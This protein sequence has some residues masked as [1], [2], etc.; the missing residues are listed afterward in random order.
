[1]RWFSLTAFAVGLFILF[2]GRAAGSATSDPLPIVE[3]FVAAQNAND[4]AAVL[5]TLADDIVFTGSG[6]T[7]CGKE[8]I[9][10]II[11]RAATQHRRT[12]T[13]GSPDVAGDT[14]TV[15]H[16]V[17]SDENRALGIDYTEYVD[18]FVVQ[19]GQIVSITSKIT[20][21][22]QAKIEHALGGARAGSPAAPPGVTNRPSTAS[23][24][25]RCSAGSS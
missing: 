13:V 9:R 15:V 7:V 3:T 6:G 24:D 1:M 11:E 19:D 21:E 23:G 2:G 14:V 4:V 16:R 12:E 22:S 25:D 20:P 17:V 8:Q 10:P 18:T 5:P